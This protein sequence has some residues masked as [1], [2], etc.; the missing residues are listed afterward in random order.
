MK[1]GPGF[2]SPPF[3]VDCASTVKWLEN[4]CTVAA[5][6]GVEWDWMNFFRHINNATPGTFAVGD[7]TGVYREACGSACPDGAT[8]AELAA[9]VDTI[10]GAFSDEHVLF[11][12]SLNN[13]GVNH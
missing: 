5:G 11:T 7:I 9:A 12:N 10:Y 13:Y 4:H 8:A 2:A 3:G 1:V 6:T